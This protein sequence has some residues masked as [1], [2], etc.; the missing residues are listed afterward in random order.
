VRARPRAATLAAA[1]ALLTILAASLFVVI[2]AADRPS[3]LAANTIQ[4]FFPGWM[5]GPLGGLWPSLTR[6]PSTLK[7]LVSG[8]IVAMYASYLTAFAYAPR[9]PARYAIATVVAVHVVMFLCP[10]FSLTDVFN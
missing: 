9:L 1:L 10:P 8:A 5:A 2:A 7:Y 6:N 3:F 4:H